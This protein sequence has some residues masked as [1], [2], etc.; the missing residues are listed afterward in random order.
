MITEALTTY[1]KTDEQLSAFLEATLRYIEDASL[2]I[3]GFPAFTCPKCKQA[4][5]DTN[6][7]GHL[8]DRLSELVPLQVDTLFFDLAAQQLA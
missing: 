5:R 1:G 8:T 7:K 6:Q 3:V 4:G 2:A